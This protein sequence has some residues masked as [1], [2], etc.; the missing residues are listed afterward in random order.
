MNK[1]NLKINMNKKNNIKDN[2]KNNNKNKL[3]NEKNS[4]DSNKYI[5]KPHKSNTKSMSNENSIKTNSKCAISHRCGGCQYID[6]EY[7]KQLLEKQKKMEKLLGKYGKVQ[8][9]IGMD[10]P[11]YYRNKVH[12]VFHHK[13][14]N[15]IIAGTYE[16][17]TH[18]VLDSR[19]CYIEN[20]KAKEIINTV[21]ELIKSFKMTVYNEDT[22]YGLFRH[23]LVRTGH[24]TGQIMVILV[25]ASP[26]FPSKNNFVKA[27]LKAHPEITTVVHNINKM[28]NSMVLGDREQAIYGKGYIE[29]EL[30]G[31][32]FRISPKSFY[33][34]NSVQTEALYNKAIEYAELS[35]NQTVIDAYCGIGTIS[36]VASDY[37]KKVIGVELNKDAVRDAISNA[38]LNSIKNVDF[39]TNDAS[40]FMINMAEREENVDVV[41]MDPPRSGSDEKFLY[42]VVRLEPKKIVYISCG[43]D[44]LARDLEYLVDNGYDV[45]KIQPVDMFPMTE[46]VETVVLLSCQ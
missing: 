4:K 41:F 10:N 18:Y 19:N 26:Q 27:L 35:N 31:K 37:V 13:K 44:T 3:N 12:A 23:I 28:K 11:F 14:G 46:H 20:K 5:G 36:L 33:Q 45:K 29:D 7:D 43:P 8:P 42:S 1:K 25:T 39:Y 2:R 24:V 38:K 15:N 21:T 17:G 22:E 6:I 40:K 9:I 16:E 32:R 30:C 34:I